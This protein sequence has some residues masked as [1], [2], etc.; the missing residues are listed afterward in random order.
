MAKFCTNCGAAMEDDKKFCTTCGTLLGEAAPASPTPET[1]PE[2][3]AEPIVTPAPEASPVAEPAPQP[4]PPPP[5]PQPQP[6]YQ[7]PP[8]PQP[9]PIT[10]AATEPVPPKGSKY[11]P[12]T[13]W[14]YIGIFILMCI[15]LVGLILMII[16]A[17]GKCKKIAK[18]NLAR[19]MLIMTAVGLVISLII[20]IAGRAVFKSAMTAIEQESGINISEFAGGGSASAS[21]DEDSS[22]DADDLSGLLG[23]LAGL[24]GS[25]DDDI[26][27]GDIEDLEA[28]SG[29]LSGLAGLTG[30]DASGFEGLL[31]GAIEANKDAE[32]AND[33]WPKTLRKYPGG[34]A[35][36]VASYRTEISNTSAEEMMGWIDDLKKDGFQFQDFYEF[37]MSE[38]D[39]LGMNSWW[40]YDGK[41]Y[42]SV[43]Y[44]D[45]IVTVDHTKELPDL[46]SYFG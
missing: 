17:C 6:V 14:G 4:T 45:G 5:Q 30:G 38:Q 34:T 41:T 37:G 7:A 29:L 21:S 27:N 9:Q 24:G 13:T 25:G 11:A 16:W 20:G 40:A 42:L 31:D 39:M 1:A 46:S 18:R 33:G 15:P 44:Y 28:L 2:V 22:S 43:S 35:T 36:A 10:Y 32:A 8:Q 3:T 19:A 12:I 23:G 26:T